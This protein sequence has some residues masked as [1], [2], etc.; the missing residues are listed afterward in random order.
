MLHEKRTAELCPRF[1]IC[2]VFLTDQIGIYNFTIIGNVIITKTVLI[3]FRIKPFQNLR[4]KHRKILFL[5]V[6]DPAFQRQRQFP[7]TWYGNQIGF[8]QPICK[9]FLPLLQEVCFSFQKRDRSAPEGA[10]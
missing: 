2:S 1:L 4:R 9:R 5:P 6:N 10:R 3:H 8:H 7:D